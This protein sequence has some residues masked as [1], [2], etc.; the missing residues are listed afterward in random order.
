ML[1]FLGRR[2]R[3]VI[4]LTLL[5]AG[6]GV[7]IFLHAILFPFLLAGFLSYVLLR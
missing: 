2:G 5:L 6:G 7:V 4:V 3:I 1:D